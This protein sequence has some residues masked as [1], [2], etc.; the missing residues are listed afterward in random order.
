MG[1]MEYVSIILLHSLCSVMA[2]AERSAT[3]EYLVTSPTSA[4]LKLTGFS[5][6]DYLLFLMG[7]Q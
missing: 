2:T 7:S 1:F 4:Q 5:V 6:F 3:V